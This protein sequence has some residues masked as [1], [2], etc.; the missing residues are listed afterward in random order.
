MIDH[1]GRRAAVLALA[2]TAST[3]V[4]SACGGDHG[5]EASS[6]GGE[7]AAT[8]GARTQGSTRTSPTTLYKPRSRTERQVGNSTVDFYRAL[9]RAQ[10]GDGSEG[11]ARA[12][13][14]LMSRG[15]KVQTIDGARVASGRRRDCAG[16][17]A[18]LI[19]HS[20]SSGAPSAGTRQVIAV[21]ILGE[22][23]DAT[24]ED[25]TGSTFEVRLVADRG[26]WKVATSPTE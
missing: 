24:I 25:E 20:P 14:E 7:G 15:A 12:A 8:S 18:Y 17:L 10:R 4:L 9:S 5:G 13:C 16:S 11:A 2:I 1:L 21:E 22:S 6:V 23:A 19:E 26:G 3:G